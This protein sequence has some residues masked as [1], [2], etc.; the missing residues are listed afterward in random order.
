M[1]QTLQPHTPP[2]E[3]VGQEIGLES[4]SSP[5]VH[6]GLDYWR[7]K[8]AGRR[9]P[10]RADI[11]PAEIKKLLPHII[12][13]KVLDD[14]RDFEF[15]VVGQSMAAAHGIN[16]INWRVSDLDREMP[17]ATATV[18]RV[19]RIAHTTRR[20]YAS[21]GTLKHFDRSYR[22]FESLILPLGPDER[23]VDHIF[24]V[25]GFSGKVDGAKPE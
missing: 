24:V 11:H 6:A 12:L 2:T 3:A 7:D 5:I 4:I 22:S 13:A 1:L 18:M 9:F 14:G 23:T 25:A 20:P 17:G 21:R 16:P 10:S 19:Y 8:C 15:K